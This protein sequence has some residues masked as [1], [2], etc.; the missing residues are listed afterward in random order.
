MTT[1]CARSSPRSPVGLGRAEVLD[2]GRVAALGV[3][4]EDLVGEAH[5]A[6]GV[7][8]GEPIRP[9]GVHGRQPG[10]RLG[11]RLGAGAVDFAAP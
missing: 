7:G 3:E 4:V 10:Q 9:D 5:G 6:L 8:L 2:H 11:S 1:P